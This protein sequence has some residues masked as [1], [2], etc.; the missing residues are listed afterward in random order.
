[1]SSTATRS[2]LLPTRGGKYGADSVMCDSHSLI[3][4]LSCRSLVSGLAAV[5]AASAR[6]LSRAAAGSRPRL[7]PLRRRARVRARAISD[8][9]RRALQTPCGTFSQACG[10]SDAA[11]MLMPCCLRAQSGFVG[12]VGHLA[13][14]VCESIRKKEKE[15]KKKK[16]KKK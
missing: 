1:M 2:S 13:A 12:V 5:P 14:C 11:L 9:L 6:P 4:A 15:R 10:K 7:L 16:K 8:R 3:S